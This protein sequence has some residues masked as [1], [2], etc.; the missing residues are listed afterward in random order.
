[1]HRLC[2]LLVAAIWTTALEPNASAADLQREGLVYLNARPPAFAWSGC[3]VG[4]NTGVAFDHVGFA[5]TVDQGSHF[6]LAP[7]VAAV[8]AA[9]SG[10]SNGQVGFIGGAQTGCNWQTG[11]LV[12]GLEGDFNGLAPKAEFTGNGT[13]TLGPVSVTNSISTSW[14]ATVRPRVGY[15]PYRTLVYVTGGIA[16]AR[17]KFG[18]TYSEPNFPASGSS[19]A[20]DVKAGWTIGAGY[21]Y[22]FA[23]NWSARFEY[24]YA[25]FNSAANND[26][27]L[28][29]PIATSNQFHGSA[30]DLNM[31]ILRVGLSYKL[32]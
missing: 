12:F 3:Y 14:L 23:N 22:A 28:V 32:M 29:T 20:V 10:T 9:A 31:N 18:Q 25:R 26:W 7:N 15:A 2:A 30:G 5:T 19:D 6:F 8:G 11:S 13:T 1:M 24:L 27:L 21:E 16:V 17:F 4:L